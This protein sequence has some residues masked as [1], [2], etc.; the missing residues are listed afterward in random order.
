[1]LQ[2]IQIA[3]APVKVGNTSENLQNKIHQVIYSL[4]QAIEITKN[5]YTNIMNSVQR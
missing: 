1:M 3:F 5:V 4:H 2:R